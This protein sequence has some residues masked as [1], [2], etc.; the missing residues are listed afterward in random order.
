MGWYKRL[1]FAG[2]PSQ[3]A[4]THA[5]G[6]ANIVN[7]TFTVKD[8]RGVTLTD[9]PTS[10]HVWTSNAADGTGVNATADTI[11][12]SVGSVRSILTAGADLLVQTDTNGVVTLVVT[13]AG[14]AENYIC[15]DFGTGTLSIH[16]FVTADYGA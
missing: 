11:T 3:A 8:G 16:K 14:K 6:A 15:A 10:F 9:Y 1:K 4:I 2:V 12:A 5:A 7:V 13:D